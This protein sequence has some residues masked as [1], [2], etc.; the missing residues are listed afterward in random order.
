MKK[1]STILLVVFAMNMGVQAALQEK[2]DY[3]TNMLTVDSVVSSM[4]GRED[5]MV[6]KISGI[7]GGDSV[8]VV[9][10]MSSGGA[11]GGGSTGGGAGSAITDPAEIFEPAQPAKEEPPFALH[12]FYLSD[13]SGAPINDFYPGQAVNINAQISKREP[14]QDEPTAVIA[15][16]DANNVLQQIKTMRLDTKE[17]MATVQLSYVLPE[18][19]HGMHAKLFLWDGL[20]TMEPVLCADTV[21]LYET[22]TQS[23]DFTITEVLASE[24]EQLWFK[25]EIDVSDG[26]TAQE[27]LIAVGDAQ[28]L[29][30]LGYH[31]SGTLYFQGSEV[32]LKEVQPEKR[33][34][35]EVESETINIHQRMEVIDGKLTIEYRDKSGN[36]K[37]LTMKR[38]SAVYRNGQKTD[39]ALEDILQEY[40]QLTQY[41]TF[42]LQLLMENETECETVFI[43]E[44]ENYMVETR[45]DEEKSFVDLRFGD[46][47]SLK[48][49]IICGCVSIYKDGSE[50]S[51]GDI[52]ENDVLTFDGIYSAEGAFISGTVE[53]SDRIVG[54][55]IEEL[56]TTDKIATIGANRYP[57]DYKIDL[58]AGMEKWFY[59]N[60]DGKIVYWENT[61]ENKRDLLFVTKITEIPGMNEEMIVTGM[62]L[63]GEWKEYSMYRGSVKVNG[64][65]YYGKFT[66]FEKKEMGI[67]GEADGSYFVNQL[68]FIG[69]NS[70][71]DLTRYHTRPNE[72]QYI[73]RKYFTSFSLPEGQAYQKESSSF[74]QI[75]L[76]QETAIVSY[77]SAAAQLRPLETKDIVITTA[78]ALADGTQAT[79][80]T[81]AYNVDRSMTATAIVGPDLFQ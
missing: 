18:Q 63:D 81:V 16:M 57:F 10:P 47:V 7:S 48:D 42:Q 22:R 44:K 21:Y 75:K 66:D 29:P 50:V 13:F 53:V 60:A 77:D 15:V 14:V 9:V 52:Q 67:R 27:E 36:L 17:E 51:F 68:I 33:N 40:L 72:N 79:E 80:D 30:Y 37:L 8:E 49:G 54:G 55:L 28:L 12:R 73:E 46:T 38:G 2:L 19:F 61:M 1:F 76:N 31:C 71:G 11:G 24:E 69:T 4:E 43:S 62:N 39:M 5:T 70:S 41:K 78:A 32:Q 6:T 23:A 58:M 59:L 35:L 25:L 65:R 20:D 34:V 26:K 45:S 3:P 56:D 74:G 64:E